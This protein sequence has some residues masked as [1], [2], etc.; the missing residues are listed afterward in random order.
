MKGSVA[1]VVL[2]AGASRRLGQP[3][4]LLMLDGET[5][6]ARSVRLACEA[7]AAPV[8]VVVGAYAELTGAAVPADSATVVMNDKWE[9]G[10][11]SSIHAGVNALNVIVRGVLILACD[12]PRL[13]AEHL[14]GLIVKFTAQSEASIVASAYAGVLGIPAIFPREVFADLLALSGDRGARGLLMHP[15]CPMI[16]LPFPGGAVDIDEPDDLAQLQ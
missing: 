8:L 15:P 5:L 14:R 12:Q 10:I 7:D 2:A 13:S 9:Q 3:K 1:A 6:V 16:T 11:A 4:Q